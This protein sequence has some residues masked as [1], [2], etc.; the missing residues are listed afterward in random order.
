MRYA[1]AIV[2]VAAA[3][4]FGT[5]S[6]VAAP[7]SPTPF[8]L[9][10]DGKNEAVAP[11]VA[12]P[13]GM[14]H[15]GTF[16]ATSPFCPSGS[17]EDLTNDFL[18]SFGDSRLYTCDDG[19]GTLT[20]EQEDWYE[21]KPPYTSTWRVLGGTGRYADLRGKGSFVGG[22]PL[23]GGHEDPLNVTYRSTFSGMVDFDSVAPAIA[24]KSVKTTKLQRPAGTYSI[25][26]AFSLRDNEAQDSLAYLV[27]VEPAGGGLY[28]AQ[29]QGSTTSGKA[30]VTLRVKPAS[31]AQKVLLQL[32]VEDPVG[33][34]RW[35]TRRL[36]LP[37]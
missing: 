17:F 26:V 7:S 27:A 16:A 33:N 22:P 30:T 35:L 20:T 9:V 12:F 23:T 19:S 11:S 25:R 31:G 21:L 13:N 37:R 1:V 18:N 32:R 29:K 28:L 5:L 8:K 15:V 34:W 4:T 36:K 2:G 6:A 10:V 3:V 24:V 14:R